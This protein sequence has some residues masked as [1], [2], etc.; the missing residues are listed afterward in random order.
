MKTFDDPPTVPVQ[1]FRLVAHPG[2]AAPARGAYRCL[3]CGVVLWQVQKGRRLPDCPSP[4]CP[5]MWLWYPRGLPGS[6]A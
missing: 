6:H 5:T 1:G 4:N 2:D 3:C